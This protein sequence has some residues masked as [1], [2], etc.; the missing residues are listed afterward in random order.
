MSY[1]GLTLR[2][3]SQQGRCQAQNLK[4]IV[5]KVTIYIF[6]IKNGSHDLYVK[7]VSHSDTELSLNSA[8]LLSARLL[9]ESYSSL[10]WSSNSFGSLSA[11]LV[12]FFAAAGS[13]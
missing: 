1:I 3:A 12:S 13:C 10:F 2:E 9:R 8:V 6:Y 7:W 4:C 11:L 5:F